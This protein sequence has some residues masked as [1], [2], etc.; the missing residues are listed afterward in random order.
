MT[1]CCSAAVPVLRCR[2]PAVRRCGSAEVPRCGGAA[3][4]K[5]CGAEVLRVIVLLCVELFAVE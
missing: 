1:R 5:Y 2:G 4:P 3:V